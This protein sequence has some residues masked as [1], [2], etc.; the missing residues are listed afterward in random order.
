M[1]TD[2]TLMLADRP[3]MLAVV[4]ETL[5]KA[6]VNIEAICGFPCEGSAIVHLVV[7]DPAAARTALERYGI[8]IGAEREVVMIP[9]DDR[10]GVMGALTRKVADEGINLELVYLGTGTRAV[11]GADDIGGLQKILA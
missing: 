4:G 11:L 2:L 7:D 3:G 8:E 10:P 9:V 6:G 1:A 5:G